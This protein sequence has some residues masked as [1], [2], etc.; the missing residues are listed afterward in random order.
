MVVSNLRVKIDSD[1]LLVDPSFGQIIL[2]NITW[3]QGWG[4]GQDMNSGIGGGAARS[5]NRP[6]RRVIENKHSTDVEST[7]RVRASA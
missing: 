7:N 6:G 5:A 1:T 2:T 4:E 3:P